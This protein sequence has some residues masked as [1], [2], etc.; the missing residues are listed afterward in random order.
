MAT[1]Q[2]T[3]SQ[4][5]TLLY[6]DPGPFRKPPVQVL[7]AL[8]EQRSGPQGSSSNLVPRSLGSWPTH[9]RQLVFNR[10]HWRQHSSSFNLLNCS[11]LEARDNPPPQLPTAVPPTPRL[12]CDSVSSRMKTRGAGTGGGAKNGLGWWA[13]S[14]LGYPTNFS[15]SLPHTPDPFSSPVSPLLSPFS[16]HFLCHLPLPCFYVCWAPPGWGS[17]ASPCLAISVFSVFHSLCLPLSIS[18]PSS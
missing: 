5:R 4:E 17:G 13:L 10:G 16:F 1:R 11:G 14:L 12:A 15:F 3:D 2:E 7:G 8:W 18:T 9:P 6:L